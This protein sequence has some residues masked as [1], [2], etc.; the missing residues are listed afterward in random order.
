M[1]D[2]KVRDVMTKMVATLRPE[3]TIHDAARTLALNGISG[4]PVVQD[5][6]PIGMVSEADIVRAV[7]PHAHV[8]RGRPTLFDAMELALTGKHRPAPKTA[9][10]ADVMTT[11]VVR[12]A[13]DA[14]IWRAADVMGLSNV[15]RLPVVDDEGSLVGIISRADLVRAMAKD[16]AHI[17][18]DARAA[19]LVLGEENF[20]SLQ[21]DV[22]EGVLYLA[23]TADRRSTHDLAIRIASR[24]PGVV[25]VRDHL[26]F[27]VDDSKAAPRTKD[28]RYDWNR[29]LATTQVGR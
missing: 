5:G 4:A 18:Q 8:V 13:P 29:D 28:P 17:A 1:S 23:G 7:L 6:K 24:V 15:K 12:I 14:S 10:A 19:V 3:D 16:D 27:D 22:R 11:P 21:V 25:E 20:S 26:R 2:V 9:K